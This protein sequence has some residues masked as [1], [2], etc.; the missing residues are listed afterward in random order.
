M[1]T[2]DDAQTAVRAAALDLVQTPDGRVRVEDYLTVLAAAAGEAA[3]AAAGFD[4]EGHDLPPGSALFFDPVNAVLTGDPITRPAAPG[5]VWSLIEPLGGSLAPAAAL[6]DPAALYRFVVEQLGQAD[7]GRVSTSVGDEHEPF[8]LPL[9]A[10]YDLRPAVLGIEQRFG[11]PVKDRHIVTTAAL[12]AALEQ[13]RSAID[14]PISL[15]LA[16][17]VLFGMA[18]MAPMTGREIAARLIDRVDLPTP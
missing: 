7:W 4:V 17:E 9:K 18:K 3:L 6:P 16:V 12:T 8:L 5:T 14:V 13:T 11:A 15:R 10:A 2:L 1:G